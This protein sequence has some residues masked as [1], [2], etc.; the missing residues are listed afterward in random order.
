MT[1]R[2]KLVATKMVENGGNM[3]KAMLEAGY[4]KSMAK[5][6]YKLTR[7]KGWLSFVKG[8]LSNEE[9]LKKHKMLL[10]SEKITK[11]AFPATMSDEE[12]SSAI[13]TF[14]EAKVMYIK[15]K[16]N[17]KTCFFTIP[18]NA[19]I[20]KAIELAYKL[21]NLLSSSKKKT[22]VDENMGYET[23]ETIKRIRRILPT[24]IQQSF[25][26]NA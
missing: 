7:S 22:V 6:P 19:L 5:N 15:L 14:P 21:N 2:Q 1:Y 8:M 10:D 12:I 13:T 11:L 3:G 26:G 16:N 9:I 24:S 17:T 23:E 4:S 18:N 20:L 25:N